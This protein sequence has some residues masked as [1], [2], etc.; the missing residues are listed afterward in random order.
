[1]E[2]FTDKHSGYKFVMASGNDCAEHIKKHGIFEWPLIT[3]CEQFCRPDKLFLDIG[4]HMGTYSMHLSK[5]SKEVHAFE[6]QK[7]TSQNLNRGIELNER[8]NI[9]VH[10]FALSDY[11]GDGAL[12]RVSADGGGST[13]I[14]EVAV[15]MDGD[16]G[17]ELVHIRTLDSFNLENVG[18]LKLD[19]E[20]SELKVLKGAVKTL[21]RSGWPKFIFEAWPD[22]WYDTARTELTEFITS[23]GYEVTPISGYGNMYL[24][25]MK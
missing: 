25:H 1:M 20:G 17:K 18:F 24:A 6:A 5:F 16:F 22:E 9:I 19:V 11:H 23:L 4:A 21:E 15:H 12:H 3:W 2:V 13:L 14:D 7:S 8:D 10:S